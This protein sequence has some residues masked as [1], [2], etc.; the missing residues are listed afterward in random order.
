M[1]EKERAYAD[2]G[3]SFTPERITTRKLQS[4]E[5]E[6]HPTVGVQGV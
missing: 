3:L 6:S 5:T 2:K 4:S 1:M